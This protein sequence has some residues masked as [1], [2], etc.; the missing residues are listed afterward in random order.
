MAAEKTARCPFGHLY[1]RL[2]ASIVMK[3]VTIS[4]PL[5]DE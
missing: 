4:Y 5:V 2:A 1:T 3:Y